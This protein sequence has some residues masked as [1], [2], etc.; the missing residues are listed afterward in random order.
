MYRPKR[1]TSSLLG[2]IA[3]VAIALQACASYETLPPVAAKIEGTGPEYIIGP[4]DNLNI[5]VWR[6]PDVSI[7][8][9]VRPDG[10]ISTPLIEDLTATG[11]T[12]TQL[13][14]DI[15][16]E[17]SKFIQDPIVTVIVTG[18]NG[19]FERQVRVVGQATR[20]QAIPY[21]DNM[22][23]LDVMVAVG[24]ITEFAAGNRASIVRAVDNQ[25]RQYRVR[26]SD[27]VKDGDVTANVQMLPGD[28]LIIPESWF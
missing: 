14:R 7:T 4:L 11:K 3:V 1:T 28:I 19:P 13:A 10:R 22:T 15:E 24:G 2:M 5:F 25:Q 20:P 23:L 16:G 18:F 17:L 12:P 27:L 21:R 6:N 26:L 8:V 9:P